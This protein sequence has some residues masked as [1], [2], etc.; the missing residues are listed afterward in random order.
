M[1]PPSPCAST[2]GSTARV[3]ANTCREVDGVEVV[4]LLVGL[5]VERLARSAVVPDVV[6]EHVDAAVLVARG[7]HQRVRDSRVT[8]VG[9]HR[10][11]AFTADL[12]LRRARAIRI[13]LREDDTRAFGDEPFDDAAPDPAPAAG[14]D[15]DLPLEQGYGERPRHGRSR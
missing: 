11:R 12:D 5:L 6:D 1:L 2:D 8:H 4:P 13:D 3:H 15:R 9:D 10:D 14:D 7:R